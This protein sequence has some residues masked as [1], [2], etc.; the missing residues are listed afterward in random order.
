MAFI[1]V[2]N[3]VLVSLGFINQ[4]KTGSNNIHFTQGAPWTLADMALLATEI[5]N[6]IAA[7]PI[8]NA[9]TSFSWQDYRIVDLE[10]ANSPVI[11]DSFPSVVTGIETSNPMPNNVAFVITMRTVQRGRSFRGRVYQSGLAEAHVLGNLVT[12]TYANAIL[13]WWDNTITFATPADAALAVVSRYSNNAPRPSGI[14]TPV[15]SMDMNTR[16]DTQ[17]RRMPR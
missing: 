7:F 5:E 15:I 16:V 6:W 8:A 3:T 17:R 13:N 1:P 4:G 11:E 12:T 9:H 10:T 2:P 14:A